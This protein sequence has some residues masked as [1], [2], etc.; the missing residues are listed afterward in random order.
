MEITISY[1]LGV[2]YTIRL[3]LNRIGVFYM[4]K[5]ELISRVEGQ[6]IGNIEMGE[7]TGIQLDLIKALLKE[8]LE[9]YSNPRLRELIGEVD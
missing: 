9:T 8:E 4:G 6:I 2:E 7:C 1:V 5:M 3:K